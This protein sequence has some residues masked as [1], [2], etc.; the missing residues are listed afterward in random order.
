MSEPLTLRT[1][2]T[3][4]REMVGS[5]TSPMSRTNPLGATECGSQRLCLHMFFIYKTPR[6][7]DFGINLFNQNY[8][9]RL[10]P[11]GYIR[12]VIGV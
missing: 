4:S 2:V 11:P 3:I 7:F 9:G 10:C 8:K 5:T 12:V 1:W 6:S